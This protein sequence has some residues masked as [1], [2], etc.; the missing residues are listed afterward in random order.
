M[1][2]Y[3]G[4]TLGY[5][6]EAVGTDEPVYKQ[7][8]KSVLPL[9]F[10]GELHSDFCS[11]SK[12]GCAQNASLRPGEGGCKSYFTNAGGVFF[13]SWGGVRGGEPA[14]VQILFK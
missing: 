11:F 9:V 13:Q 3:S 1:A 7:V 12:M 10:V 6:T 4:S 8:G 5:R 2:Q 14:G